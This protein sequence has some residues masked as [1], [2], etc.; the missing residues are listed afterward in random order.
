MSVLNL[1]YAKDINSIDGLLVKNWE[2]FGKWSHC[3]VLTNKG[4]VI[5]AVPF[6]GVV[7][8]PLYK[9]QDRFGKEN[10]EITAVS[11]PDPDLAIQFAYSQLGKGYDYLAI[12][13]ILFRQSWQEPSAWHCAELVETCLVKGGSARFKDSPWHISPN[14][15]YLVI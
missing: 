7:E 15:S 5:E 6:K 12:L 1:I 10:T 8:T 3:G 2:A 11:C 4:T 13:G 9:F 14:V